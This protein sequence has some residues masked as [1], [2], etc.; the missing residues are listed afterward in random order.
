MTY[1]RPTKQMTPSHAHLGTTHGMELLQ[2]RL[3]VHLHTIYVFLCHLNE[4]WYREWVDYLGFNC[5]NSHYKPDVNWSLLISLNWV[6][7]VTDWHPK[8]SQTQTQTKKPYTHTHSEA[9][10][11]LAHSHVDTGALTDMVTLPGL[12]ICLMMNTLRNRYH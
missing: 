10:S 8:D 11:A 4:L 3:M 5:G 7:Q 2:R 1:S 9:Q 6:N 12:R